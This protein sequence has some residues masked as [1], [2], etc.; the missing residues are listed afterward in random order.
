[1]NRSSSTQT[2]DYYDDAFS[3]VPSEFGER[4]NNSS[5]RMEVLNNS[6]YSDSV[7]DLARPIGSCAKLKDYFVDLKTGKRASSSQPVRVLHSLVQ[8]TYPWSPDNLPLLLQD[9]QR[10]DAESKQAEK[11][12]LTIGTV[13]PTLISSRKFSDLASFLKVADD[14]IQACTITALQTLVMDIRKSHDRKLTA[15]LVC[16]GRQC[17]W[18]MG[19]VGEEHSHFLLAF[20]LFL[21]VFSAVDSR[22]PPP[23]VQ[24]WSVLTGLR[25]DKMKKRKKEEEERQEEQEEG[26]EEEEEE[27]Q[28]PALL[29]VLL[30]GSEG[31]RREM[32]D[33][34]RHQWRNASFSDDE[35]AKRKAQFA[36]ASLRQQDWSG[37]GQSG[38]T[39]TLSDLYQEIR[40]RAGKEKVTEESMAPLQFFLL[41]GLVTLL[42]STFQ[43][44]ELKVGEQ[45]GNSYIRQMTHLI[46]D[47]VEKSSSPLQQHLLDKVESL[48]SHRCLYI[49]TKLKAFFS[50]RKRTNSQLSVGSMEQN[51]K[52]I[53][54]HADPV[55]KCSPQHSPRDKTQKTCEW[56]IFQCTLGHF[57]AQATVYCRQFDCETHTNIDKCL[58]EHSGSAEKC[59]EKKKRKNPRE[60]SQRHQRNMDMLRTL[61]PQCPHILQLFAYQNLP[62]PFFITEQVQARRLL[63]H[64]LEHR[65]S[66]HWLPT[67]TLTRVM[68]DVL[69]ALTYLSSRGIDPRDVTAYNM[70]VQPGADY[71]R[72]FERTKCS[73]LDAEGS[74]VVQIADLG[75]AHTY[76]AEGDASYGDAGE[77]R[78]VCH[79]GPIPLRWTSPESLF[80]GRCCEQSVTFSAGSLMYEL[81]THGC[82]PYASYDLTTEDLLIKMLMRPESVML[83]HWRCIPD[84]IFRLIRSCTLFDPTQRPSLSDLQRDLR[85]INYLERQ[86]ERERSLQEDLAM[87]KKYPPLN[88]DQEDRD[89]VPETGIPPS[90]QQLLDSAQNSQLYDNTMKSMWKESTSN[91]VNH[92]ELTAVDPIDVTHHAT[93]TDVKET[94]S[95]R[96]VTQF[97]SSLKVS[98][99]DCVTCWSD[100]KD[101]KPRLT[102]QDEEFVHERKYSQSI[103]LYD[104]A[105]RGILLNHGGLT[106]GLDRCLVTLTSLARAVRNC[107]EKGWLLRDFK[108]NNVLVDCSDGEVILSRIGRMCHE[109]ATEHCY[110]DERFEDSR[111]WLAP[112]VLLSGGFAKE[113]DVF[114]LGTVMWEVFHI[115]EVAAKDPLADRAHFV[116]CANVP[117]EKV[118]EHVREEKPLPHGRLCPGWLRGL[119]DACRRADPRLRPPASEVVDTILQHSPEGPRY[120]PFLV[121]SRFCLENYESLE[122][123]DWLQK[124]KRRLTKQ[125]RTKH[126]SRTG[127]GVVGASVHTYVES[128]DRDEHATHLDCSEEAARNML[129]VQGSVVGRGQ[130]IAVS[131]SPGAKLETLY[132]CGDSHYDTGPLSG[133]H[134]LP[135]QF[136][137]ESQ[138]T[139]AEDVER[140]EETELKRPES[141]VLYEDVNQAEER[142][143]PNDRK[144]KKR[145]WTFWKRDKKKKKEL[146]TQNRDTMAASQAGTAPSAIDTVQGVCGRCPSP[147]FHTATPDR[148]CVVEEIYEVDCDM[149]LNGNTTASCNVTTTD[150]SQRNFRSATDIKPFD[151]DDI[152]REVVGEIYEEPDGVYNDNNTSVSHHR[153]A[154]GCSHINHLSALL[155][156]R[157]MAGFSEVEE[158]YENLDDVRNTFVVSNVDTTD[159]DRCDLSGPAIAN[160]YPPSSPTPAH[161]VQDP[162]PQTAE[163]PNRNLIFPADLEE[164]PDATSTRRRYKRQP[165]NRPVPMADHCER[166]NL[167][168]DP[169]THFPGLEDADITTSREEISE[170]TSAALV[171]GRDRGSATHLPLN[172]VASEGRPIEGSLYRTCEVPDVEKKEEG[173]SDASSD[174][175]EEDVGWPDSEFDSDWDMEEE[176]EEDP[177]HEDAPSGPAP[178]GGNTL[179][180]SLPHNYSNTLPRSLPHNYSNTLPRSLPPIH[181]NTL[182]RSLPH[183]YSNTLPLSRP[184]NHS[185]PAA[186]FSVVSSDPWCQSHVSPLEW[187]QPLSVSPDSYRESF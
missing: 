63:M 40:A 91:R 182:P 64:V 16:V 46:F 102:K 143:D 175:G 62:E 159:Y 94:L 171:S 23:T 86:E 75:L 186:I 181:S 9:L 179:P 56:R 88:K 131:K 38:M 150:C 145:K 73:V 52:S 55:G 153:A 125:R 10:Y 29:S 110:F 66:K 19:E 95:M 45:E 70:V 14:N 133:T 37:S 8:T 116:P 17:R 68:D 36:R 187:C 11:R 48:L 77:L 67:T 72:S 2:L 47:I 135:P 54:F 144:K 65:S 71:S 26:E 117:R 50:S 134:H 130:R 136:P 141:C 155:S 138:D 89:Y 30:E 172:D 33:R 120:S 99:L 167:T 18:V 178:Y 113:S 4:T 160:S 126:L 127:H 58:E 105:L 96:F 21:L 148:R 129:H 84:S 173:W 59:A 146:K 168:S 32:V 104:A 3:P 6:G 128:V 184:Q 118:V 140:S 78:P 108:A 177:V 112:E 165:T 76:V 122:K 34:V 119:I 43:E 1:M 103:S 90:V 107:H 20:S 101:E 42:N 158:V 152:Y 132:E 149:R 121:D 82:Q 61:S 142:E 53:G 115:R 176:E 124:I 80:E 41:D 98:G 87:L 15:E 151:M 180:R 123:P 114:T 139:A 92:D 24:Q 57:K 74:F 28:M 25:T 185:P 81:W 161:V 162:S 31:G 111:R 137:S 39:G 109:T 44:E 93:S 157:A 7:Y 154:A 156:T 13:L 69:E 106:S 5:D 97:L 163:R 22:C 35:R 164:G 79:Q 183:N 49:R 60:R 170:S 12:K 169:T 85:Q 51:L 147:H 174:W 166:G 83:H 27:G 100:D